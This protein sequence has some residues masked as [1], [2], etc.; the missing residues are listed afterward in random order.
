MLVLANPSHILG[1]PDGAGSMSIGSAW[2]LHAAFA[3]ARTAPADRFNGSGARHPRAQGNRLR[4][5]ARAVG[6]V[7]NVARGDDR[8]GTDEL[9]AASGV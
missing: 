2:R 3:A 7:E 1:H 9:V 4:P 5:R 6:L 8:A